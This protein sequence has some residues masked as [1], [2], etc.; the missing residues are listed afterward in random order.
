VSEDLSGKFFDS[1]LERVHG[2]PG[3]VA[4]KLFLERRSALRSTQCDS[5]RYGL[6]E[7][8]EDGLA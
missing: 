3:L 1:G 4:G 6:S 8:M 5:R 7:R 2:Q